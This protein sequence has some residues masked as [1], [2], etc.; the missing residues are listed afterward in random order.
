VAG[1]QGYGLFVG[2]ADND[3][4]H[5]YDSGDDGVIVA[6]ASGNLFQGG[7]NGSE[8]FAVS[9]TGELFATGAG[10]GITSPG[11]YKLYCNGSAAKPGGGSWSN[12]SDRNL[13]NINGN[14]TRGLSEILQ[15]SPVAYNYKVNNTMELPSDK[16]YIGLIAQEVEQVIPEAVE[17]MESGYLSV[18]ND[19]IIWTML[20]AI[21]EQQQTI[22]ELKV[23]IKELE[24]KQ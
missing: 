23:R 9:N 2:R 16:E 5:I 14:F 18:N 13:K 4:V 22:E 21:K 24:D 1:S 8:V 3:G 17:E 12:P 6:T 10:I 20:N 7:N 11:A 15:L 19:P